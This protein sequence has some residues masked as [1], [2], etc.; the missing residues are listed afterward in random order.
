MQVGLLCADATD[1]F[2]NP[3][4]RAADCRVAA[5]ELLD[6]GGDRASRVI[7]PGRVS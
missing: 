2:R 5:T 3:K 4:R 6:A 1:A 7:A